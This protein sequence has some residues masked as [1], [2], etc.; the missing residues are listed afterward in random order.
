MVQTVKVSAYNAGDPGTIPRLG[1]SPGE[2]NGNPLLYSCP[3]NSMDR[4]VWWATVQRVTRVRHNLA[5]KPPPP[6]ASL[7]TALSNMFLSSDSVEIFSP[8]SNV[9]SKFKIK[10]VPF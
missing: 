3:E 5:T 4:E 7:R 8:A 10:I 6:P 2:G 1:R 9:L